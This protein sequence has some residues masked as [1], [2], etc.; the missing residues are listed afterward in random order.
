MN[1]KCGAS[2]NSDR[3]LVFFD[4]VWKHCRST[5]EVRIYSAEC[6]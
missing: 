5:D 6:G 1:P 2:F 4:S 3:L